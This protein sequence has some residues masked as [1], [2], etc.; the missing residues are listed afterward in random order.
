MPGPPTV[1]D[2]N[3]TRGG[4]H[5]SHADP[6]PRPR[7]QGV[8]H[9]MPD[10]K[11]YFL[12]DRCDRRVKASRWIRCAP[13]T[14]ADRG[15]DREAEIRNLLKRNHVGEPASSA[16]PAA[17]RAAQD[18]PA[19]NNGGQEKS[20]RSR[21]EN[22]ERRQLH[23]RGAL[24]TGDDAARRLRHDAEDWKWEINATD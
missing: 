2:S 17:E 7:L 11:F 23:G 3:P 1:A 10:N 12:N 20:C 22:L 9:Y 15:H 16:T 21:A 18:H 13:I 8:R 6:H 4:T 14:S 5:R 19:E 24:H